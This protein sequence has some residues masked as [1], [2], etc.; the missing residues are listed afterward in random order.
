MKNI[1]KHPFILSLLIIFSLIFLNQQGWLNVIHNVFFKSSFFVQ[2]NIFQASLKTANFINFITSINSLE[3][4]NT[5]LKQINQELLG[6]ITELKEIEREN[7]LLR[8]QIGV[9]LKE[10]DKL[11]FANIIGKDSSALGEYFLINKGKKHGIENKSAVIASGNILVGQISEVFDSFSRVRLITDA[12]SL[13]YA[14]I[15]GS[16]IT[17]LIKGRQ[18]LDLVFDLLPQGKDIKDDSVVITSG[19]SGLFPSGLLIGHIKKIISSD[20][21]ISQLAE[22]EPVIDFNNLEKVF[23]IIK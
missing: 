1:F 7:E 3:Q 16:K 6:E 9:S 8:E 11:V 19:L 18:E 10:T 21:Q 15:Q 20:A 13:V 5:D 2:E 4:E 14:R 22:I 12:N 17:G 23:V